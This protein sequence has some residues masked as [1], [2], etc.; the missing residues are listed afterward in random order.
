MLMTKLFNSFAFVPS[1]IVDPQFYSYSGYSTQKILEKRK[2]ADGIASFRS[3]H[4]MFPADRINPSEY[5][6]P[7]L[8]LASRHYRWLSSSFA[9]YSTKLRMYRKTG[10][11]SEQYHFFR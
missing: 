4:P 5:I 2:K 10:F 11:I 3:H 8:M 6:Q 7:F 1:C 9:P